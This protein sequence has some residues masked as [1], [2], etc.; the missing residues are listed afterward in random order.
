MCDGV[1]SVCVFFRED[2]TQEV[3]NNSDLWV[4]A[5]LPSPTRQAIHAA[6]NHDAFQ[7]VSWSTQGVSEPWMS[8]PWGFSMLYFASLPW[9]FF[10]LFWTVSAR[11]GWTT[12]VFIKCF[13]PEHRTGPRHT[14][15]HQHADN[16]NKPSCSS[17]RL[18]SSLLYNPEHRNEC[19]GLHHNWHSC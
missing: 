16:G 12:I 3:N 14:A 15:G 19:L 9:L 6:V 8:R 11:Y 4:S 13:I 10:P 7:G 18:T 17:S 2:P 1:K 5:G